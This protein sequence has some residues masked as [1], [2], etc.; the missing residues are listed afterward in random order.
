[1][2]RREFIAILSTLAHEA[3]VEF[4]FVRNGSRHDIYRVHHLPI[5]IPRHRELSERL[6]VREIGNC[7]K[8]L[9]ELKP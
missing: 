6:T 8:Y 2:K 7:K 1:V 3:G 4:V 9:K 5:S